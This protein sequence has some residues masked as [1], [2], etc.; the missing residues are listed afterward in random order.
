[1]RGDARRALA[2][3]DRAVA[4]R[5]LHFAGPAANTPSM[6]IALFGA[7]GLVGRALALRLRRDGHQ[8]RAWARNTRRARGLLGAEVEIVAASD[9]GATLVGFLEGCDALVN[10]AGEPVAQRWTSR[11]RARLVDSRVGLNRRIAGALEACT[12]APRVWVQASAVGYYGDGGDA[13]LGD[14]AESGEGFLAELCREWE[15]SALASRA[16]GVRVACLRIGLVLA[17]DGGVLPA[18]AKPTRLGLGTILGSGRQWVPWV[19]L[20]DLVELFVTAVRDDRYGGTI[21]AVAP[22][23]VR[24]GAFADAVAR[25]L[26]RPRLFRAPAFALRL[27][28]GDAAAVVLSGQRAIPA[29]ALDLGFRFAYPS[30]PAALSD[31]LGGAAAPTIAAIASWPATGYLDG[32]R[33]R[34]CLET[35]VALEAG[36]EEVMPFFEQAENLGAMTPAHMAFE[37][38]GTP[39][40][41]I[42]VGTTIDYRIRV[43]PL[44][45]RWRTRIDRTDARGFVDCQLRGPYRAWYHEHSFERVGPR[46]VMIDRVWYAPPLGL[47]GVVAQ[48]L[49]VAAQLRRIFEHR[50]R[51]A[52]LRFGV[53]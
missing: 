15:A 25:E 39:P 29:R 38:L 9:D 46:T 27:A 30:L 35:R 7:T 41:R 19:H 42:E 24:M 28:L 32:R 44:P 12:R 49:F 40:T 33:P 17:Q 13:V 6:K 22:E 37:I 10:V 16:R 26:H 18:M 1:M 5:R 52:Q 2:D 21:N 45:L 34:Y 8:V 48:W 4:R 36:I 43:G 50:R 23:P 51:A 47:V 14:D 20:E 11:A 3:P 31:L 53:G